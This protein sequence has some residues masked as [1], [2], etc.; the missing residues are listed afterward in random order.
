MLS[1][2]CESECACVWFIC[3]FVVKV[4]LCVCSSTHSDAVQLLLRS[5]ADVN[6]VGP[7]LRT[8]LIMAVER[9]LLD[10]VDLL[11]NQP[12]LYINGQVGGPVGVV[13]KVLPW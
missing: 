9:G 7:N 13:F 10:I 6:S 2:L 8:P 12:G 11:V 1:M 4:C 3:V 5:G